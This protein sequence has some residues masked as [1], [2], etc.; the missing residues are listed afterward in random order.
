MV[1]TLMGNKILFEPPDHAVIVN[2]NPAR[3]YGGIL[4]KY[5]QFQLLRE[6]VT[7]SGRIGNRRTGKADWTNNR[8]G[9]SRRTIAI[10]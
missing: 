3:V 8:I 4:M 7:D 10:E 2:Q 1:I 5:R 6:S 9:G